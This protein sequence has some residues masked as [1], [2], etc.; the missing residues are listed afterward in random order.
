MLP[1]LASDIASNYEGSSS[2]PGPH[3]TPCS[4]T[5]GNL[6]VSNSVIRVLCCRGIVCLLSFWFLFFSPPLN[7]NCRLT[8]DVLVIVAV[9]AMHA[10]VNS[11]SFIAADA[12]RLRLRG[13]RFTGSASCPSLTR[14]TLSSSSSTCCCRRR[15]PTRRQQRSST[16]PHSPWH[17]RL[18]TLFYLPSTGDHCHLAQLLVLI[19]SNV[20]RTLSILECLDSASFALFFVENRGLQ[21]IL[22]HIASPRLALT[23][24]LV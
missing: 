17:Q 21:V 2:Q 24:C 13:V 15:W 12:K 14:F 10:L 6:L 18:Q 1:Q 16:C 23:R 9:T 3:P 8:F 7:G 4:G 11:L 22:Q 5:S 19:V 20:T